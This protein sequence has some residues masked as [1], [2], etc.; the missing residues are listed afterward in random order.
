MPNITVSSAS[1]AAQIQT[2]AAL[3]GSIDQVT[4]SFGNVLARQRANQEGADISQAAIAEEAMTAA[5]DAGSLQDVKEVKQDIADFVLAELLPTGDRAS[6]GPAKEEDGLKANAGDGVSALPGN[7]LPAVAP[8]IS[9]QQGVAANNADS[10][11]RVAQPTQPAFPPLADA[12]NS[13]VVMPSDFG[14]G[15]SLHESFQAPLET[16][17]KNPVN[18]A[19][20]LDGTQTSLQPTQNSTFTL[21]GS[22][23]NGTAA[24]ASG[25]S[26]AAQSELSATLT[27]NAWS[28]EFSQKIVWMATQR[29]QTAELHLNPPNLGPL[30]VVISVSDDQATALFT[31][32]HAAVRNAVEQAL[33]I[34][35]QMLADNGITLGNA[36]VSDQPPRQRQAA[37]DSHRQ[38]GANLPDMASEAASSSGSRE[39][40][41]VWPGRRRE[42]MVDTFA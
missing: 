19:Q 38:H 9:I 24:L 15:D 7:M 10:E 37:H 2:Q 39:N 41:Q 12:K 26:I 40:L 42:G 34:L 23:Q 35:R 18:S 1:S 4:E 3:G 31:S 8:A 29:E 33:P 14:A 30:D 17:G 16:F 22:V 11:G 5:V 13:G 20:L 6:T 32:Q 27:S 21:T 25:T 28:G 36:M